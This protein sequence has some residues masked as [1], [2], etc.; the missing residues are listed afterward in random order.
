MS[1]SYTEHEASSSRSLLSTSFACPMDKDRTRERSLE[2]IAYRMVRSG[3]RQA[4]MS[5]AAAWDTVVVLISLMLI[6]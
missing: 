4:S 6:G 3:E 1:F 5:I 2:T